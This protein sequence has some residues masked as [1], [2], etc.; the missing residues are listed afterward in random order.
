MG[1]YLELEGVLNIDVFILEFISDIYLIFW[2][3]IRVFL[4]FVTV[5]LRIGDIFIMV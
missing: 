5:V 3:V 4:F 1:K 2:N